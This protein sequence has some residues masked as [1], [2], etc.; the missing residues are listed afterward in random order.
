[1]PLANVS[2]VYNAVEV[3][4]EP[5]GNVMFYGPGAG[6]GA[7]ASAVVGDLMQIMCSGTNCATPVMERTEDGILPF[8]D[9]K[10][11]SYIALSGVAK[12]DV[13]A[14][15]GDVTFIDGE[16]TSFITGVLTESECEA[17]IAK[18]SSATLLSRIRLL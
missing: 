16:E 9:F 1:M 2:S 15:F 18:L 17:L 12:S 3:L 4:G 8:S 11:K 7:T 5:I 14:V 10:S 13:T 6:A